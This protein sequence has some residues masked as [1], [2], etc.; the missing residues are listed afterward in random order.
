MNDL[1]LQFA[2]DTLLAGVSD[3]YRTCWLLLLFSELVNDIPLQWSTGKSDP[4]NIVDVEDTRII[5]ID[6]YSLF[7]KKR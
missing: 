1:I 7:A 5:T 6:I 3:G 4:A 2:L